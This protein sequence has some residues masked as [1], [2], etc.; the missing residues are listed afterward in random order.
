MTEEGQAAVATFGLTKKFRVRGGYL[1]ALRFKKPVYVEALRGVDLQVSKGGIFGL[2]GPN[3]A[4]KTTLFK[5]LAGLVAPTDGAA[6][7]LDYELPEELDQVKDVLT[8]VVS[9]E[10]SL[11]W[12]LTG[13]QNLVFYAALYDIAR[14]SRKSRV[15]EVLAVVGMEEAADREVM[16]YST[17]MKQR[18]SLARG[19]LSDPEVLLLDEPTRSLDPLTAQGLWSFI[20]EELV[21]RQGKT[22]MVATD[23]LEEARVLCDRLAI[24]HQGQILASG[25]VQELFALLGARPRYTLSLFPNPEDGLLPKVQSIPGVLEATYTATQNDRP[26]VLEVTMEEPERQVPVVV[27]N[28]VHSGARLVSCTPVES[29]LGFL[30]AELVRGVNDDR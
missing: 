7:V 15:Q 1:D 2:L 23:N 4:G 5:I 19:L 14:K 10:R 17:G 12:R 21:S 13:R 3:G 8:Y 20:K 24:L 29:S 30:L 25:T 22:V 11:Y 28:V 9:E 16:Y 27:E 6:Q 26:S 18:L